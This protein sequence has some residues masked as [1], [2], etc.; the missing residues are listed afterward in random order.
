M[1]RDIDRNIFE[2]MPV[3]RALAALALPTILSQLITTVYNL[4]DAFFIGKT[5][6]PYKVAALSLTFVLHLFLTAIAN[7]FGIGGG[8]LISR[9]LGKR[10][11]ESAR[12]M[13]A[14]SIYG[15]LLL[16]LV[17][18]MGVFIFMEPLLRIM[19]ASHDTLPYAQQYSL[20]AIIIGGVPTAL[21]MTAA[22]ILRSV[23]HARQASLGIGL[24]GILNIILDPIFMFVLLPPGREVAGAAF[25]TML[26][27]VFSMLFLMT[28]FFRLKNRTVLCLSLKGIF[29]SKEHILSVF[30]V[31]IPA[32]LGT[33]LTCVSN[34]IV[35]RT[36]AD[37]GDIPLAAAGITKRIYQFP[38]S[39]AIGLG[40]GMLPLVAYNY[41]AGND[42]RMKQTVR[43]TMLCSIAFAAG[44]LVIYELLPSQIIRLFIE[45]N[46]T[47]ALASDF[48][49]IVCTAMP[50][51]I[52]NFQT[53]YVFQAMGMGKEALI[54]SACRQGI[55]Q[56]P[57]IFLM[58]KFFKLYGVIW[59]QTVTDGI[60]LLVSIFLYRKIRGHLMMSVEAE[61]EQ[62]RAL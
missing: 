29:R 30:V 44:V 11:K 31:G 21:S 3:P 46:A 38:Y 56:I 28:C 48:L 57:M 25:A 24:G 50:F 45:E 13:C 54:V 62:G 59:A 19:G 47:V 10:E 55:I 14:F 9:L 22:H 18:S 39:V 1:S 53:C 2:D 5:N 23:G 33:V 12:H 36:A 58:N 26:S 60:T 35:N 37:Y 32:A 27:N 61:D 7:L 42:S 8:S 49:R 16:S 15:T 20:W 43:Y 51:V 41:A 17:Y 6:D 4:A 34:T 40:Q 52:F